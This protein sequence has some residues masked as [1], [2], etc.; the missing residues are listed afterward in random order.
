MG[1]NEWASMGFVE[2]GKIWASFTSQNHRFGLVL[3]STTTPLE[4]ARRV[5]LTRKRPREDVT[6]DAQE[7]MSQVTQATQVTQVVKSLEIQTRVEL[8]RS[9][10]LL[11]ESPAHHLYCVIL[12]RISLSSLAY[13]PKPI[14]TKKVEGFH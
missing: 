8:V 14:C 9:R 4:P 12:S 3:L 10:V 1:F 2:V 13:Q 11:F 5:T 6:K 7:C